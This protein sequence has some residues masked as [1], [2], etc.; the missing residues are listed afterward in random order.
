M[1]CWKIRHVSNPSLPD[2]AHTII[3]SILFMNQTFNFNRFGLLLKLDLAEKGRNYLFMAAL[4]I[5]L[6]LLLMVPVTMSDQFSGIREALHIIAL[7]MVMLLGSSFFTSSVFTQYA[8]S[9]TGVAALMI[10]AS[11]MEKF[12]SALVLNLL[13]IVPFIIF[14]W[15]LHYITIDIANAGIPLK[16]HKY[17]HFP[18]QM[19]QYFT[20]CYFLMHACVLLGSI[21]FTKASYIKSAAIIIAIFLAAGLLQIALAHQFT[22]NPDNISTFPLGGWRVWYA[23]S[24]YNAFEVFYPDSYMYVLYGFP[25]LILLSIWSVTFLRLKEKEI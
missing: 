25:V 20:Y 14:F 10:P 8:S 7:F 3:Y 17:N 19:M 2:K 1:Q 24:G 23:D 4:L 15:Q 12:L 13:F 11:K 9:S 21:Y 22:G 16:E 5:I 18:E 6:L